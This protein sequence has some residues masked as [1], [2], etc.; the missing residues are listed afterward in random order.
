MPSEADPQYA[1]RQGIPQ[2]DPTCVALV[3]RLN[4]PAFRQPVDRCAMC[5]VLHVVYVPRLNAHHHHHH[6]CQRGLVGSQQSSR[7]YNHRLQ[8][9]GIAITRN[10]QPQVNSCVR[11]T[12]VACSSLRGCTIKLETKLRLLVNID[13]RDTRRLR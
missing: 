9:V 13:T 2:C 6:H 5:E 7:L 10:A 1:V 12:H 11:H 3:K 4:N 8:V